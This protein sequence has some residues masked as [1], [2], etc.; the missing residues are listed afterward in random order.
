MTVWAPTAPTR[1]LQRRLRDATLPEVDD[2]V[3]LVATALAARITASAHAARA[4]LRAVLGLLW[5][6]GAQACGACAPAAAGA[7]HRAADGTLDRLPQARHV[8]PGSVVAELNNL[9]AHHR[10][11]FG[12]A[13]RD[14]EDLS[15]ALKPPLSVVRRRAT[16]APRRPRPPGAPPT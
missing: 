14:A 1:A 16:A 3:R 2:R 6:I 5:A 10:R 8:E 7:G 13:R 12:S 15:H 11:L 4:P 9:I